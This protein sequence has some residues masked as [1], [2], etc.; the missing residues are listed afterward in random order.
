[1]TVQNDQLV[2]IASLQKAVMKSIGKTDKVSCAVDF[3]S[4]GSFVQQQHKCVEFK[5]M[6]KGTLHS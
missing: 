4:L 3:R 1:M 2:H 5:N 6:F